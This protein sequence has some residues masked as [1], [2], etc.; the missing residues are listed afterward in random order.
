VVGGPGAVAGAAHATNASANASV[1]LDP[2]RQ[3]SWGNDGNDIV[4]FTDP[5]TISRTDYF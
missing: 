1:T 3:L 4:L 2:F 5:F